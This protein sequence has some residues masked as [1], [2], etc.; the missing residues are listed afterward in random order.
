MAR[1]PSETDFIVPVEG[2]G[3]FT[4]ARRKLKDEI[5]IQV[6]FA[7][8]IEGVEPT[9]WLQTVGGWL[10]VLRVLTVRAPADF[11]LDDLDPLDDD[12]YAKLGKVHDALSEK[13]RSF[14]RPKNTPGETAGAQSVQDT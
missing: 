10:S 1:A 9:A 3:S 12:T 2:V 14:R 13:E 6:E 7:R 8:I 4:F 11:V 5:S